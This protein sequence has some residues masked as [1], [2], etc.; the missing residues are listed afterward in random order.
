[1]ATGSPCRSHTSDCPKI[2]SVYCGKCP[3]LDQFK[4]ESLVNQ[5]YIRS[6]D[7]CNQGSYPINFQKDGVCR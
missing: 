6:T 4:Q 1:M 2:G 7:C 3:A 5:I